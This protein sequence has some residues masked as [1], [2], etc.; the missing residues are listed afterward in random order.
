MPSSDSTAST[1][2]AW[3]MYGVPDAFQTDTPLGTS[4]SSE[5]L[6]A[7]PVH[8][9]FR[10]TANLKRFW[11]PEFCAINVGRQ[12]HAIDFGLRRQKAL[13]RGNERGEGAGFFNA[14]F[15]GATNGESV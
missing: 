12:R 1:I 3:S 5:Y 6:S 9:R 2:V 14:H 15:T 7:S 13:R 11:A 4:T 10:L 8:G